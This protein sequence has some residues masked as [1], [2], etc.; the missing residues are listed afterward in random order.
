MIWHTFSAS[1]NEINGT[2][3]VVR[4]AIVPC[5][6]VPREH[7]L[8]WPKSILGK[9]PPIILGSHKLDPSPLIVPVRKSV[10]RLIEVR[11]DSFVIAGSVFGAGPP[12]VIEIIVGRIHGRR[13]G[14]IWIK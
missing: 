2:L 10:V 13:I 7:S 4:V 5:W 11:H 8:Q 9:F 6:I 3:F 1:I 12:I 14:R